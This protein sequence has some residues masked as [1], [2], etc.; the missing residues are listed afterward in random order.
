MTLRTGR[1]AA[2]EPVEVLLRAAPGLERQLAHKAR[3]LLARGHTQIR[4][5]LDPPSLGKLRVELDVSDNR[6]AARI[7]ATSPD[8]LLLLQ[9]DKDELVR[10]FQQAGIEDVTVNVESEPRDT[11]RGRDEEDRR[12]DGTKGAPA[13]AEASA[14]QKGRTARGPSARRIDLIA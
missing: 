11:A 4:V 13:P 10:S 3:E 6:I 8:A 12:G 1:P 7:V 9:R 14:Q 2:P 5:T